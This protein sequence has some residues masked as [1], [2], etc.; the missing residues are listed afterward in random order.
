MLAASI[1][2][3]GAGGVVCVGCAGHP[4]RLRGGGERAEMP[5]DF[6]MSVTRR[7]GERPAWYVLDVD[8][9]LRAGLG[10]R[11]EESALPMRVRQL[12]RVEMEEVWRLAWDSGL[13]TSVFA[14]ASAAFG[15][16]ASGAVED[17]ARN[18]ERRDGRALVYVSAWGAR[19]E[20]VVAAESEQV[21][22][23]EAVTARLRG[24]AWI[25]E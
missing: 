6:S 19:R 2:I 1:G 12:T 17:G 13:V 4:A 21:R 25:Q 14:S 10:E 3:G 15:E 8:G 5:E 11:S 18:G 7:G 20:V 16:I 9:G 22:G 24:L 23:L